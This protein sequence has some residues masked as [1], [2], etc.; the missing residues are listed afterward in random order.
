MP[1]RHV[2]MKGHGQRWAPNP[3]PPSPP[4]SP[5]PPLPSPLPFSLVGEQAEENEL[6]L[7][8]VKELGAMKFCGSTDLAEAETWLT[9]I[10]RIFEVLQ[11]SMS[12]LEYEHKFNELSRFAPKLV[13]IIEEEIYRRFEEGLWLEIQVV[14]TANTYFNMTALAQAADRVA[15][16]YSMSVGRRCRDVS[17]LGGP[18]QDPSKRGGSSSSSAG[19]GCDASQ[20]VGCVLMQHDR[21]IGYAPRQLKKHEQNYPTHDLELA[22]VVFALKIWRH[23]LYD[24][25]CTIEYHPGRVNVVADALSRRASESLAHVRMAYLSLLIE[26]RKDGVELE[27]S[28]QGGILASLHVRPI[29]VEWVIAAQLEDPILCMIRLE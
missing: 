25:D 23:Y 28:Q 12:V 2:R 11:G 1:P 29:L 5:S 24:Y 17:G 3:P 16:K 14:V 8:Y 7:R 19:S 20:G 9:D 15:K 22:A 18:S 13:A 4:P 21:V 27:M 10:E 6:D 26:L